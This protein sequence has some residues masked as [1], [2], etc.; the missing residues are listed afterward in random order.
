MT[1]NHGVVEIA[2]ACATECNLRECSVMSV[3]QESLGWWVE[4]EGMLV[5]DHTPS[6][7]EENNRA[8]AAFFGS[9]LR[10]RV[11]VSKGRVLD[12]KW[13]QIDFD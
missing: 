9:P 6:D 7:D 4:V 13:A 8:R 12:W 10:L 11:L 1:T 5:C 3:E 2:L